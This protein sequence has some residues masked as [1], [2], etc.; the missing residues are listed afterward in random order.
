V[1]TGNAVSNRVDSGLGHYRVEGLLAV[2][3]LVVLLVSP[4]TLL[5][6]LSLG[7][8]NWI[9]LQ[10][11]YRRSGSGPYLG[12]IA[13]NLLVWAV[14]RSFL[15][16]ELVLYGVAFLLLQICGNILNVFWGTQKPN[17]SLRVYLLYLL[18]FPK[19]LSGPVEESGEFESKVRSGRAFEPAAVESGIAL[20]AAGLFK[21][22]IIAD[23]LAPFVSSIFDSPLVPDSAIAVLVSSYLFL[24]QLYYDFSGYTDIARGISRILGVELA[25]N[26]DFPFLANSV[27]EYWRRWHQS[28]SRWVEKY[29]YMPL[30]LKR[31]PV[32]A[33]LMGIFLFSG[34]WHGLGMKFLIWGGLH[35]SLV[36][37][38]AILSSRI[39]PP[40]WRILLWFRRIFVLTFV[41]FALIFFRSETLERA[42][43]LVQTLFRG[44]WG[45]DVQL[46]GRQLSEES[47][48]IYSVD[49]QSAFVASLIIIAFELSSFWLRRIQSLDGRFS[50]PPL[51]RF[52]GYASFF[53]FVL[54]AISFSQ[55]NFYYARF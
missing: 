18:Y 25:R 10:W 54:T 19:I 7:V 4:T 44:T 17:A 36:A 40:S 6:F 31:V 5:A 35:G 8:T 41:S 55:N 1:E 32:G 46:L 26:F 12:L 50:I 52:V 15:A 14:L 37:L 3:V 42:M 13:A 39:R 9:A 33:A 45:F 22:I 28:F 48:L 53:A 16:G 2:S 34:F 49:A 20:I 21:K 43:A 47:A 51:L 27:S 23:R 30:L 29:I 24:F 11:A 38:E